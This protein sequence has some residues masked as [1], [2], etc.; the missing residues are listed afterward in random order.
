MAPVGGRSLDS[1]TQWIDAYSDNATKHGFTRFDRVL[2]RM[3]RILTPLPAAV[4]AR[5][6]GII[7]PTT[8]PLG[9][10]GI[11][12]ERRALTEP[13]KGPQLRSSLQ[14]GLQPAIAKTHDLQRERWAGL[15]SNQRPWD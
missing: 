13:T 10:P 8:R 11:C 6:Q 2:R 3:Q 9:K 14:T 7:S 4:V 1:T 5:R 12:R 15:D